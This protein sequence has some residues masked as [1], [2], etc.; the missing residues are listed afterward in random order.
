[1][2]DTS[3]GSSAWSTPPSEYLARR[4]PASQG[5]LTL[6][7]HYVQVRDGTR[8]AVDVYLP[9]DG[10]TPCP[11]V[12]AFTPYYR[13]FAI[14]A[15][16][17]AGADP[18]PGLAQYRDFFPRYGYAF[19]AVDT[20]GTG[21]SFGARTGMRSPE[22]RLDYHDIIDWVARQPWSS[23]AV[24]ITGISYVGAAAD[25]A[26][27]LA[28]PAIR[29]V[30]PVS[31]VWDT[32]GDMFYPGGL[33]YTGMLGGYGRMIEALDNDRRDV[34]ADYPYFSLPGLAG[35]APVDD[36]DGSLLNQAITGHAANFDTTD[37][38]TQLGLRG[39]CL[40]HDATFTTATMAPM[41]YSAAIP[42]AL[43]HYGISGWMDGAG[44]TAGAISRF[45]ALPNPEKRLLLGPWDHGARTHVSPARSG[46]RP[47]FELLAETLRFF[48]EH[49]AG[50]DTGL[51]HEAK[52]HYFTMIEEV[53]QAA[54]TFPPP[55]TAHQKWWLGPGGMLQDTAPEPG[56]DAYQVDHGLG[57]GR[58]TRYERIAG[59]AVEIYYPD[60]DG[61]DANMRHWTTPPFHNAAEMTGTPVAEIWLISDTPDAAV[62]LYLEDVAPD[63]HTLYI[64]EGALRASLRQVATPPTHHPHPGPYHPS[65]AASHRQL[66]PGDPALLAIALH[67]TSWLIRP[68]H[69][70]RLALAGADRDHLARVPWGR[71]PM[72]QMLHGGVHP[73]SISVPI[74]PRSGGVVGP[75]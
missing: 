34:L 32:W 22:E 72:F 55:G 43:P 67:P 60:W 20:R 7:S 13:R 5:A 23:G 57:T 27:S 12:L 49:V 14:A 37:F 41:T 62:I 21:A 64:T 65:D 3:R 2:T 74:V 54:E 53:W 48:D 26:A 1:M 31:S 9:P 29:A 28:H 73:S 50:H 63:G 17:P 47:R 75:R 44:Y 4:Q 36:D 15:D 61:R 16:A 71:S 38:I 8:L 40:R 35:P 59:A 51:L 24:G 46:A 42:S 6:R 11:A 70:L 19:V 25:F 68:G 39:E 52:V 10:V 18:A 58:N 45:H 56:R 69:R 30:M 66:V 33:L